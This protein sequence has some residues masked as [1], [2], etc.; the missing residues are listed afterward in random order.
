MHGRIFRYEFSR[1]HTW[2]KNRKNCL[3]NLWGNSRGAMLS[4]F[5]INLQES[6]HDSTQGYFRGFSENSSCNLRWNLECHWIFSK[7]FAGMQ[8]NAGIHM[9]FFKFSP[10]LPSTDFLQDFPVNLKISRE[11]PVEIIY[12][13]S[14]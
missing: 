13:G 3:S 8:C 14:L 9:H 11:I 4:F 12:S 5:K 6:L 1:E 2:T 7:F 10:G